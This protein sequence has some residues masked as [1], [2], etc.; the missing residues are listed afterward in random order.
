[1]LAGQGRHP[2]GSHKG[3][4]GRIAS[5]NSNAPG[6]DAS[7]C[8][9]HWAAAAAAARAASG[10]AVGAA[11]P[12]APEA[13][14]AAGAGAPG[15][16]ATGPAVATGRTFTGGKRRF[17]TSSPTVERAAASHAS[18]CGGG[19]APA[20]PVGPPSA[21]A[22]GDSAP[23]SA[24]VAASR[25]LARRSRKAVAGPHTNAIAQLGCQWLPTGYE[26]QHWQPLAALAV[27]VPHSSK[28]PQAEAEAEEEEEEKDEAEG[29][30]AAPEEPD[31][32][33]GCTAV[34]A[35]GGSGALRA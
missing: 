20:P 32:A 29:V 31:A 34:S 7:T 30:D 13:T 4:L 1:M 15:A 25:P 8:A 35:A 16:A 10:L 9:T 3:T 26:L 21:G 22:A 17:T 5:D 14:A 18:S 24:R 11:A 6:S 33:S 28:W 27:I 19:T 12:P 23:C 2:R